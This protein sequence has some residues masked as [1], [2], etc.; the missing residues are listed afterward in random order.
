MNSLAS[1]LLCLNREMILVYDCELGSHFLMID[2][3]DSKASSI[4][5]LEKVWVLSGEAGRELKEGRDERFDK[6]EKEE[7]VTV[8][9]IFAIV[10]V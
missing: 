5:D 7:N 4:M 3:A 8:L 9:A 1:F 2:S 6:E 10:E